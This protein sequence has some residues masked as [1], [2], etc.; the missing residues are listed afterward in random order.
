MFE[1]MVHK[2]AVKFLGRCNPDDKD[3][4]VSAVKRLCEDPFRPDLDV[5]KLHGQLAG[6]YRLRVGDM[7]VV[8]E[9]SQTE[10]MITVHG[11]SCRGSSY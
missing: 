2:E 3:R 5:K 9:F 7:R 8:Y 1:L 10:Q 4:V 11:I 6:L